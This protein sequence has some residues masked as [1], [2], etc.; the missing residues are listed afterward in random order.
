MGFIRYKLFQKNY[1]L[2]KFI[3]NKFEDKLKPNLDG[4]SM[5]MT[6]C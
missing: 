2:R 5:E 4:S 1:S 6:D 3:E